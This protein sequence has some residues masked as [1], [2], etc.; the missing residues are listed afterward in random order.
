MNSNHSPSG[1]RADESLGQDSK[2]QRG[3][4]GLRVWQSSM[5]F[6][7]EVYDVTRHMPRSELYALTQQVRKAATS[8]PSN[9]AEGHATGS[10]GLYLRRVRDACGS[11]AEAETQLLIAR[12]QDFLPRERANS[13]LATLGGIRRVLFSLRSYLEDHPDR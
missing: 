7:D 10:I 11:A 6:V 3:Y 1:D 5:D 2:S 4:K 12:R 13:V 8:V 9:L